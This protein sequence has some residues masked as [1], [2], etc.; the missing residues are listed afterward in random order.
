M[1]PPST[2]SRAQRATSASLTRSR[3]QRGTLTPSQRPRTSTRIAR[4]SLKEG[5][6]TVGRQIN[7]GE[8]GDL[9]LHRNDENK[10][11]KRICYR[12]ATNV[13]DILQEFMYAVLMFK[14]GV[15]VEHSNLI[16]CGNCI[17]FDMTRLD[18]NL[19]DF[20]NKYRQF[21]ATQ[22][23]VKSAHTQILKILNKI[24]SV[25]LYHGD[26]HV[27]NFM[28]TKLK[29]GTFKWY[30]IDF[31]QMHTANNAHQM[32]PYSFMNR[33]SQWTPGNNLELPVNKMLNQLK[34]YKLKTKEPWTGNGPSRP[35][36]HLGHARRGYR[37]GMWTR[38]E[39]KQPL[40][41]A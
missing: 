3:A 30:I 22:K 27:K 19:L 12:R 20:L 41:Y 26:I 40:L 24:H 25:G 4:S 9:F 18:G 15:G 2:R 10:V 11:V 29:N 23:D 36:V 34:T 31:G 6:C 13:D 37:S 21:G 5:D 38:K 16:T 8:G 14:L 32:N 17:Q 28:F 1:R 39:G 33:Q 7:G 35:L